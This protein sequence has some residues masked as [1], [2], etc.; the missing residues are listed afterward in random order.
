MVLSVLSALLLLPLLALGYPAPHA[1][2]SDCAVQG[3]LPS[4]WYHEP[5]H[6][7][8]RL[9]ARQNGNNPSDG[10]SYPA[11]G[12]ADWSAG[13]PDSIPDST[14]MPQEWTNALNAAVAAGKI[15]NTPQSTIQGTN[16]YYPQGVNAGGPEICSGSFG[17]RG[18]GDI[19][20]GPEGVLAISFDDGPSLVSVYTTV[21]PLIHVG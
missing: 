19:W 3:A 20:D 9:F 14:K 6:R 8:E 11:V 17:C 1:D 7:V 13:F 10:L 15:P 5:G 12:T 21:Y 4:Q 2:D 18:A 16:I